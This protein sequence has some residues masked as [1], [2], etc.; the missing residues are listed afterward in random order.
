M[1]PIRS[2]L[3]TGLRKKKES[4]TKNEA[5]R[6]AQRADILL[7][8]PV[9]L[10]IQRIQIFYFLLIT[11]E[12]SKQRHFKNSQGR[13]KIGIFQS[14]RFQ[15]EKGITPQQK[16]IFKAQKRTSLRSERV[17]REPFVSLTPLSPT[18]SPPVPIRE[19]KQRGKFPLC[20]K[21]ELS[22][23]AER[24]YSQGGEGLAFSD[25]G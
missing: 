19:G 16:I 23:R 11:G 2:S 7:S 8:Y 10:I 14:R 4:P 3:K 9:I 6:W 21:G 1:P 17:G 15:S 5:L 13:E 12:L 22:F 25:G 20:R 18:L 24:P